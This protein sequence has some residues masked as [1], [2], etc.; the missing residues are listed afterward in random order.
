MVAVVLPTTVD[1]SL[2]AEPTEFGEALADADVA[3][4]TEPA[5]IAATPSAASPLKCRRM[6]LLNAKIG[7][8]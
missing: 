8:R 5:T 1:A 3:P 2:A 6:C 7:K 4:T